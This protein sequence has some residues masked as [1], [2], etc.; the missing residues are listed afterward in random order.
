MISVSGTKNAAF[1]VIFITLAL[2]LMV[3]L[4]VWGQVSGA[5]ITGTV[6]DPSG[7]VVPNAQVAIANTAT[8]ITTNVTTNTAGLYTAP[9][10]L[11]GP[12]RVTVAAKG[13]QTEARTGL[14]LTVGEEQELNVTLR[15][16]QTTQ[17][18][19]VSGQAP[20]VQ[21]ASS[22]LSA[23]VNST[24]VRQLPLNGRDWTQLATLQPAVNAVVTQ[25]PNG[26]NAVRGNRGFGNQLT[27]SGMRPQ[28]NNYRLDGISIVDYAGG[29]PGSV[30]G[31]SL[32]V[33]AVAEFS[34][35]TANYSAE[36]GRTAGGVVNA[37]TKSGTNA[38]HG[39]AYEF[40]R[41]NSLDARNF[42]DAGIPSFRRNQFGASAGGPIQKDKTF[43]FADYEGFRQALGITNVDNVPSA[44]ARNGIIHNADG[45]TTT[46]AVSPLVTPYLAFYPLPN[47]GLIGSTGNT[48]HFD[49]ATNNIA[50]E[51]FVTSRIDRKISDNDSIFG[52]WFYDKGTNSAPDSL[53]NWVVGNTSLRQM[54][55]IEE[56][57]I[58]SPSVV[59]S[60]RFGYSRVRADSDQA[61]QTINPASANTSLGSFA[62]RPAPSI[63]VPGLTGFAGGL[64]GL[65]APDHTWNSFQA[66]DDA[67]LTKGN[68]SLKFGFAVERMQQN[69]LIANRVNGSF[70]FPSL[71]GFLTNQPN[72][73]NGELVTP[74]FGVRQTL[75]GG[76]AQDDWRARP[77]LTLNMGVRYEMVTV[78]T[79]VQNKLV[80]LRTFTASTPHLGSPYFQNPTLHNFEPRVGFAWD[81]FHNGKTAVRGA[82]GIFDVLP[83]NYEFYVAEG[84][85]APFAE[86]IT[87]GNLPAGS[88]PTGAVA[89]A[90]VNPANLASAAVQY[91]PPRNYVMN[92]N[93]NIQRQ[94]TPSTTVTI[95]YEGNHGVHMLDRE[96]DVNS[97]L[98]TLTSQGYLWPSP[99][100]SG[101]RLNPN[102]GELR[103]QYWDGSSLYDALEAQVSKTMSHGL[104]VQGSY[105]W[106]KVIDEGSASVIGD[107]FTNS[108]S[109]LLYF[110][111]S[112]RRGVAD[113]NISQ[114]LVANYLWDVPT[115]N[116]WGALASH[117][118]GGWELGGIFTAETGVPI[119]PVIGGDPLG[120]SSTDPWDFPNRLS[121]PGCQSVVNPGNPNNYIKLNCFAAPSPVTLL[122]NGGRNTVV[123]PGL[124]TYDFSLM[125]NIP[126]Q[127]ISENFNVQ[128]R[129][130]FFNILNRPNF[131]T[132][133][134]NE[135]L[136]G[137][138]GTG[139][140][141]TITPVGGAGS[142]DQVST[143]GREIQFALKVIW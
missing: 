107:P 33:D 9:N 110:C 36:Y 73:F 29:A 32:G 99:T 105:T 135:F 63:S 12:Y 121:I 134:D 39:D 113:F 68:H 17:T 90:G 21:L 65:T 141:T 116:N 54:I 18:V 131:A 122:G 41:N 47:A 71:T 101:T 64:G 74:N 142:I 88:F 11:P 140:N 80:N 84:N 83:L 31:L 97:V 78:P 112:C 20:T 35:L 2:C 100:G 82:F 128:F 130:E 56:T 115:P 61:L 15:V 30:L 104:Q 58:F 6:T 126:I 117:V 91:N 109:S 102:V 7:A 120:L 37:I 86:S 106:G 143:P 87:A 76:Y 89:L 51:N 44:D 70:S 125:K 118:L 45:T 50:S 62:G 133:T 27:I 98:P 139:I 48:G 10:L 4:Q 124:A 14:T 46:I 42:F 53:N 81:P 23:Q 77:N 8:G 72:N 114:T 119:T 136:F 138:T 55:A 75:L 95:G 43:F 38:F 132:P 85:S 19:S 66:Y 69:F 1:R 24:T 67:F 127:R 28:L 96:D 137:Q 3:P 22:T 59:N 25:Q 111:K 94:L 129:A 60:L 79:E 13:F 49:V 52:T 93:L 103:G 57:H 108:I 5:T 92:W 40:L 34:V 16:G 26:V 123:G